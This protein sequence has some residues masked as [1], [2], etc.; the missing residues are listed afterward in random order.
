MPLSHVSPPSKKRRRRLQ[1]S[2]DRDGE[3]YNV[4]QDEDKDW[5]AAQDAL[6]LVRDPTVHTQASS[7]VEQLV[8]Q[9]I[10]A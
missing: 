7:A 4:D 8:W 9:R 2:N 3:E 6:R 10:S 5:I 1:N